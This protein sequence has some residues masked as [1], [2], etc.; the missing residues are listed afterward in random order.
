MRKLFTILFS[1]LL[2]ITCSSLVFADDD[3]IYFGE[4]DNYL[5]Y[6]DE[7][8][9]EEDLTNISNN[10]GID[11]YYIYDTSIAD[12]DIIEFSQ[13][14]LENHGQGENKVVLCQ[15]ANYYVIKAS[16]PQEDYILEN[17]SE[18]W[19]TYL[20]GET[21]RD[22]IVNYYQFAVKLIN[23]QIYIPKVKL[24]D[25]PVSLCDFEDLLHDDE[26]AKISQYLDELYKDTGIRV[27]AV[28]IDDLNNLTRQ[29]YADDFYDYN[30][31]PDDGMVLLLSMSNRFVYISTKGKAMDYVSEYSIDYI[32]DEIIPEINGDYDEDN[33]YYEAFIK[34]ADAT[35]YVLENSMKGNVFDNNNPVPDSF[36]IKHILIGAGAGLGVA[37]IV[38]LILFGQLKSVGHQRFAHNYIVDGSFYLTGAADRFI[39]KTV[40]K[41]ARPKNDSS[42]GSGGGSSFHTSSSGSSHGGHGRSF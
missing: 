11:I 27:V 16:G 19:N 10:Y 3:Y 42:S 14:Y 41:T 33:N 18:L 20:T 40:T 9:L 34:Y 6:E 2:I 30:G 1:I 17:K 31:Y 5:S 12:D 15:N 8:I 13:N 4:N 36:G 21:I 38:I 23:E 32:F 37:L 26:E 24:I 28:T 22:R 25:S 35:R 39:N 29:D 7:K